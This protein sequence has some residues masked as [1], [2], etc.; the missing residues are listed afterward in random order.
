MTR[1][2][3]LIIIN[4]VLGHNFPFTHYLSMLQQ[5]DI[6]AIDCKIQCIDI[7]YT[8]IIKVVLKTRIGFFFSIFD[9][10]SIN[11]KKLCLLT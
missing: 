6:R 10:D 7:E 8:S 5:S 4:Y 11:Q 2:Y 9:I 1:V 3:Q